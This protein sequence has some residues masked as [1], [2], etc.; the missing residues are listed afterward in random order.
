MQCICLGETVPPYMPDA[1][2]G[3]GDDPGCADMPSQDDR[4]LQDLDRTEE[5]SLVQRSDRTGSFGR[6]AGLSSSRQG[7]DTK[8]LA[9]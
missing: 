9:L 1:Q 6:R 7:V 5:H 8:G 4:I 2:V 3:M